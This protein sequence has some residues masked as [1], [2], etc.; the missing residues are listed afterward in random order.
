[1]Q[2]W[3][4]IK[5]QEDIKYLMFTYGDFHDSC[6]VS[7]NFQSGAYVDD[8]RSM[9]FGDAQ[10]CV[11]SVVFQRQWEPKTVELQFIGLRQLHLVG[12]QDNYLCEISEAYLSFHHGLLPGQPERVIVWSDND[13]F[14]PAQIDG[15]IHEPADTYIIANELR[16]RMVDDI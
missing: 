3:H 10:A 14:D 4:P 7:L 5:T 16:W 1:M 13:S 2:D 6:I 8:D 9:Y 12:W 15:T 11:L